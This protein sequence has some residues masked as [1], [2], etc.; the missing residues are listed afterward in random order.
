M[1]LFSD[2]LPPELRAN[3][4]RY[5]FAHDGE[6]YS[7]LLPPSDDHSSTLIALTPPLPVSAVHVM[8]CDSVE[9]RHYA[10]VDLDTFR[11][12]C[13][14]SS[15]L[16]CPP[17]APVFTPRWIEIEGLLV[18]KL[19]YVEAREALMH[20]NAFRAFVVQRHEDDIPYVSLLSLDGPTLTMV[21]HLA[22]VPLIGTGWHDDQATPFTTMDSE[23]ML[24]AVMGFRGFFTHL[25]SVSV[26]VNPNWNGFLNAATTLRTMLTPEPEDLQS[27]TFVD[28]GRLEAR[29]SGG[30]RIIFE[31]P[32][33]TQTWHWLCDHAP[34]F[35]ANLLARPDLEA[36]RQAAIVYASLATSKAPLLAEFL[37][38]SKLDQFPT[39]VLA[40]MWAFMGCCWPEYT[41]YDIDSFE[42][43]T[44]ILQ[45]WDGAYLRGP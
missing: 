21:R 22:L 32:P 31:N 29:H 10:A 5:Y 3:I 42:F 1:A 39:S 43:W 27:V 38:L 30:L 36:A 44:F 17:P 11:T 9:A 25:R 34:D 23:M 24:T 33:L 45:L 37:C 18:N 7:E 41:G 19:T 26:R 15:M 16:G 14:E 8:T 28:V 4:F 6:L 12:A 40:E 35:L 13:I 2:K 20:H